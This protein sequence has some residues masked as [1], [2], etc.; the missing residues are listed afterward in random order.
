[1]KC[2][3]TASVVRWANYE[4]QL[5][6]KRLIFFFQFNYLN[7]VNN[8]YIHNSIC[9]HC[10]RA[11]AHISWLCMQTVLSSHEN[12]CVT[13]FSQK[14]V[15][16]WHNETPL[17]GKWKICPSSSMNNELLHRVEQIQ[18]LLP[19]RMR[20]TKQPFKQ[21]RSSPVMQSSRCWL[22][23]TCT[24]ALTKKARAVQ[25]TKQTPKPFAILR[26]IA[27]TIS[28]MSHWVTHL[29]FCRATDMEKSLISMC[30]RWRNVCWWQQ[31]S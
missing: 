1:M 2:Q 5:F 6:M 3:V 9:F 8:T 24:S 22:N 14:W 28:V 16:Q 30:K 21:D 26:R 29:F 19:C 12:N 11:E 7:L 10:I 27:I 18:V 20:L 17:K 13:L 25:W 4:G 31:I 15:S 23:S